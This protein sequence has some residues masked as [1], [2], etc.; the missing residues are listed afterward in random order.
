MRNERKHPQNKAFTHKAGK[1]ASHNAIIGPVHKVMKVTSHKSIMGPPHK[2]IKLAPHKA[3]IGAPRKAM[4]GA[5]RK[6]MIGAPH[7]SMIKAPHRAMARTTRT[8]KRAS[9]RNKKG[10]LHSDSWEDSSSWDDDW[11]KG[12]KGGFS[13]DSWGDSSGYTVKSMNAIEKGEFDWDSWEDDDS[14]MTRRKHKGKL[15]RKNYDDS[16]WEDKWDSDISDRFGRNKK[17]NGRKQ[18]TSYSSESDF[19]DDKWDSDSSDRFGGNK[20]RNGRKHSITSEFEFDDSDFKDK[21]GKRKSNRDSSE[22]SDGSSWENDLFDGKRGGDSRF[23]GDWSSADMDSFESDEND[24]WDDMSDF[25]GFS[26]EFRR[27]RKRS[28][29]RGKPVGVKFIGTSKKFDS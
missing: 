17:K 9:H 21:K 11:N 2:A 14:D 29:G 27:G 13:S 1:V 8:I 4:I 22:W 28:G 15:S 12:E 5:P 7:K 23:G 3:M 6:S 20:K 24:I 19:W 16:S 25:G 10:A 26:S 18:S